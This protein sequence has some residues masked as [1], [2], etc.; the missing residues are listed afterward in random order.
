MDP[1]S[2]ND[3]EPTQQGRLEFLIVEIE[4][5]ARYLGMDPAV[6]RDLMW[7]PEEGVRTLS[8]P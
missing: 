2:D 3:D 4:E 7:I 6:D 8:N 5:Y 1:P